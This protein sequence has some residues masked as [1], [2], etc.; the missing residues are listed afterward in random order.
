MRIP[1]FGRKRENTESGAA[2]GAMLMA[3]EALTDYSL[4]F[5]VIFLLGFGLVMLFSSSSYEAAV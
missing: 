5:I 1:F 4:I 3:E 2:P